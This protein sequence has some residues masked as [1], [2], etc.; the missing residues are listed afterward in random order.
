MIVLRA[1]A[2]RAEVDPALGGRL[3]S[4]RIDGD[5]VIGGAPAP[6]GGTPSWFSGCFPMAPYAGNVRDAAFTFTGARHELPRNNG[7]HATHGLVDDAPWQVLAQDDHAVTLRTEL[8]AAWPFG[9][10]VEQRIRMGASALSLSLRCGN[11]ERAMPVAL[12]FHPWFRPE[13][14]GHPAQ[15]DFRPEARYAAD[16]SGLFGEPVPDLGARP[17]DDPFVHP[18]TPR[19]DWGPLRLTLSAST[20]VWLVY[21]R[22]AEGFCVEPLTAPPDGLA[23][24]RAQ[25]ARP[26][27]P[28]RLDLRL[29]WARRA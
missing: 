5:E 26:G 29:A 22:Q 24:D 6:A 16:G 21:E 10:W 17:W 11:D 3:R 28:S 12:G 15:L 23:A 25:V 14:A 4:L 18:G 13:V 2:H 20:P 27:F 8:P 1:G 19:I 7:A 9:G